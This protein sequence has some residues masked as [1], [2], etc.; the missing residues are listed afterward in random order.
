[1]RKI[2]VI[3]D[4]ADM[5]FVLRDSLEGEGYG[6]EVTAS[7]REG[8]AMA[9]SGRFDLVLLDL[10]LPDLNGLEVC[11]AI[12][13]RDPAIPVVM[14]TAKGAEVDK[15]VGLEVGADDYVAKPFGMREL[16][17]RLKAHLRR[18]SP[19]A[20]EAGGECRI[21]AWLADF[22]RNELRGGD[23]TVRLT[24]SEA[25]LLRF[26]SA[27]RGQVVSRQRIQEEVWGETADPAN[28]TVDNYIVRLRAKVEENPAAPKHI[29]TVHGA[30][31]KL[32]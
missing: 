23:L 6:V 30:G 7:G 13:R 21:G 14:L 12:R 27:R 5:Q 18:A 20:A 15:V 3:E 31:Y 8:A 26:L 19:L 9:A 24:R 1:M 11:K 29:L 32:L 17:A 28:R 16:L 25:D 4:E 2:L 10:M 22:D